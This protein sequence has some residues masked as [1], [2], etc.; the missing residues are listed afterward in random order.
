MDI[1]RPSRRATAATLLAL[2]VAIGLTG[3]GGDEPATTTAE[4]GAAATGFP[5]TITHAF[6][7]TTIARKPQR[8]VALGWNDLAVANAL[9]ADVVG[10]VKYFDPASPNLPYIKKPLP[11][12][13]LGLDAAQINLEKVA[14]YKPDVIL[15]TSS[16]QLK[17]ETYATLSKIAPVVAYA[18]SLYGSTMEEDAQLIGKAIGDDAGAQKLIDEAHAAIE[19]TK[20]DLPNIAGKTYLYGQARGEVIPLVVGADNLST[21]FMGALGLKVPDKFANAPASDTLA[22]GTIGISYE[23]VPDLD[24]ANVLFMTFPSAADQQTFEGNALV[25]KLKVVSGGHYLAT[26]LPAAQLL[27]GPN[28][29]GV[30]WLVEQLKPT[31]Q[32]L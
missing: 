29:A 14:S 9:G 4:A 10:A 19:K 22:P 17:P 27:Q 21:K 8:V 31:L 24:T 13:A 20:T 26:P 16:N 23:R 7:S 2:T 12:E 6:G 28:V 25:K 15:A 30:S 5:L 18:K 3:C 1:L 32:K 11:E